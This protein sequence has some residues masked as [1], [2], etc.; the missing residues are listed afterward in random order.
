MDIEV[1]KAIGEYI[2]IPICMVVSLGLWLYFL[3][4]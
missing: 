3:S 4:R 1:I 2:V